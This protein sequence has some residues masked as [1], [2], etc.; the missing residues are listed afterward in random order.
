[1]EQK[2]NF[3][4]LLVIKAACSALV[5]SEV[6][7]SKLLGNILHLSKSTVLPSSIEQE[8]IK[9]NN[10]LKLS[11]LDKKQIVHELDKMKYPDYQLAQSMTEFVTKNWSAKTI[12]EK[13]PVTLASV[14]KNSRKKV[15]ARIPATALRKTKG[16]PRAVHTT[17][18][19]SSPS[20]VIITKKVSRL[21]KP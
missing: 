14:G 16:V 20:A 12:F 9:S 7:K 18:A 10:Y 6:V 1:M 4:I 3:G 2:T 11:D 8:I 5:K 19:E 13:K 15:S 21:K 17:V